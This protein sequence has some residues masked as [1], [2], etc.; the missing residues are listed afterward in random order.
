M[1]ALW[2]RFAVHF[3]PVTRTAGAALLGSVLTQVLTPWQPELC[4]DILGF[5]LLPVIFGAAPRDVANRFPRASPL[6]LGNPQTNNSLVSRPAPPLLLWV[7]AFGVAVFCIFKIENGTVDFLPVLTPLLLLTQK[8]LGP[9]DRTSARSD[10]SV[11]SLLAASLWGT[12]LVAAFTVVSFASWDS[13]SGWGSRQYALSAIP[14]VSLL[15][16]YLALIPK[17][18]KASRFLPI[19][20]IQDTARSL[21]WRVVSILGL[22][23]GGEVGLF[24][25]P[26]ITLVTLPLS[27]VKALTWY[28]TI[29]TARQYSWLSAT[30][31]G[32]FG[33][34]STLDPFI[35]SSGTQALSHVVASVLALGQLIYVL[36]K[37]ARTKS[38]L[39]TFCFVSLLPYLS[40]ILAIRI[41]QSSF[42][43]LREHPIQGLIHD[44]RADFEALLQKQST[45]YSA[46]HDEYRRRYGVEPPPGF[47]A[48][49]EFARSHDSPI[50]DE[51]DTIYRGISPFWKLSGQQV[52]EIMTVARN[53]PNSELWLCT[54]SGLAARADCNH[55]WRTFDRHVPLLFDTLLGELRGVLPDVKFLVNHLDEPRVLI[56]PGS[57]EQPGP[58]NVFNITDLSRQR[59]WDILTKFCPSQDNRRDLSTSHT[60]EASDDLFITNASSAKDLCQHPEYSDMHGFHISSTSFRLIEGLVPVLSTGSPSTMGDIL[61]PS[62]AYI[63]SEFQYVE[64]NDVDWDQKRNNLYWAGST[65]GGFAVDG[66]W[67]NHHRQRFVALAQNLQGR[68]HQYLSEQADDGVV[69]SSFLDGRLYDVGFTRIFQ[70][71]R[72]QCREQRA[73]FGRRPWAAAD[74]AL[75]SRLAFDLDGNGIS[76]RYY[77]LLASRS[78]LLKQTLLRE[79]HDERLAAWVHYVPVSQS[80]TDLPELVRYLAST[81][82]GRQAARQVADQGR[83]WFARAFRRED[84]AIYAYRLLLELAR[85]QDPRRLAGRVDIEE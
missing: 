69:R 4:S 48:W 32:T 85:L 64:A 34:M 35:Q 13:L 74:Q 21:T 9:E 66:Q 33:T 29:Q 16:V 27:L 19:F 55:Q 14:V 83:D 72:R 82:A 1:D 20:D 77:K 5:L 73:Y 12:T 52:L 38:A 3:D 57:R 10:T 45:T 36:P 80:L 41:A 63:E 40:N 78:A 22:A 62:P 26:S 7:V 76:G 60:I 11:L 17:C 75:G 56:P 18:E 37:Q 46:A 49:Y 59:A 79:W 61:Y 6:P 25:L 15:V 23:V 30:V 39:W 31:I 81:P 70:C 43:H 42:L 8:Y 51:F 68:Q 71:G 84:L 58:D 44:A 47:K 2:T 65:T 50:I 54:F 24:G 67:R 53:D 28:F